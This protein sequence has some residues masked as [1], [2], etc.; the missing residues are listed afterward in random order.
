MKSISPSNVLSREDE[1]TLT[2]HR[3]FGKSPPTESAM[4][5]FPYPHVVL[6]YLLVTRSAGSLIYFRDAYDPR[7]KYGPIQIPKS[8]WGLIRK[9]DIF[10]GCLGLEDDRWEILFL[11]EPIYKLP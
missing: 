5:Q 8:F 11:S 4:E 3:S 9:D 6:R 2:A 10:M 7:I 1:L